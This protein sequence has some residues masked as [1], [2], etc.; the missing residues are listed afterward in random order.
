[1]VGS[2]SSIGMKKS[3]CLV[4]ER[5]TPFMGF[6]IEV[7]N[8]EV[9]GWRQFIQV[10]KRKMRKKRT[11]NPSAPRLYTRIKRLPDT[12]LSSRCTIRI[13]PRTT[14]GYTVR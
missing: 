2:I 12:P 7:K 1:M 3:I 14:P 5:N 9:M 4:S 13:S 10:K 8:V 11:P 6:P